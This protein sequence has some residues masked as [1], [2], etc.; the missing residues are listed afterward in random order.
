MKHTQSGFTLI[1][2]IITMAITGMAVVSISTLYLNIQA[3]QQRANWLESATRAGQTEVEVLRNNN[4]T[5]LTS[6]TDINFTSSLPAN[7]PKQKTGV[8]HVSDPSPGLKRIDVV[9]TYKEGHYSRTV[10][11]TSYI[12]VIGIGR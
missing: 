5:N 10:T 4:Y 12:G 2:L 3:T 9:I 11:F 8:V 6:G 1:E 7:L